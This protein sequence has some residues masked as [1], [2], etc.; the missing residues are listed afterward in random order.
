MI[1]TDQSTTSGSVVV[2]SCGADDTY[3]HTYIH[4]WHSQS[5]LQIIAS[6]RLVII[7]YGR[8]VRTADWLAV[9]SFVGS[10]HPS[11]AE[12]GE[13][14]ERRAGRNAEWRHACHWWRGVLDKRVKRHRVE[15]EKGTCGLMG[16]WDLQVIR[17]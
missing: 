1:P 14:T 2:V 5:P 8:V 9:H 17:L 10:V 16:Y 3:I 6:P 11:Q 13:A 15:M 12:A 7:L 4:T